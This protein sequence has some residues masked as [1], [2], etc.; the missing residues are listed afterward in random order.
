TTHPGTHRSAEGFLCRV[1]G[2]RGN[3]KAAPDC[4]RSRAAQIPDKTIHSS[5][6]AERLGL[7]NP[8]LRDQLLL[9]LRRAEANGCRARHA[10]Q[11]RA[12]RIQYLD[13]ERSFGGLRQIVVND[14]AV[15]R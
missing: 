15:R 1:I 3:W 14:S 2:T 6:R 4:A 9:A 12:V 5:H 7:A 13:G 8:I 10:P 11:D